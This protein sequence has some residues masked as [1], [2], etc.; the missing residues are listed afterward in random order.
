MDMVALLSLTLHFKCKRPVLNCY[1]MNPQTL[2]E[3]IRKRRMDLNMTKKAMAI[4][5][6][7]NEMTVGTWENN[8]HVPP[9]KHYANLIKY[10]GYLPFETKNLSLGKQLY[11]ARQV[12]GL[13]QEK[14]SRLIKIDESS[15]R[16]I[17][18]DQRK[19]QSKI[20]KILYGFIAE[21]LK[22]IN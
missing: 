10:I 13:T 4:K 14:L 19:P 11:Y 16:L 2:G 17:E 22:I 21:N 7:V 15:L 18:L 5:F 3:H 1:P 12:A 20:Y 8:K 6:N 9:P